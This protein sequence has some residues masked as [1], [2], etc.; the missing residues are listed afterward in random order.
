MTQHVL[1]VDDDRAECEILQRV[2]RGAEIEALIMTD[3]RQAVALVQQNSFDAIFVD[4]GMPPPD[5]ME[6]TRL[7]RAS[8]TNAKTPVIMITGNEDPSIVA[9]GFKAGITFFLYKPIVKDRL[10]NL[11]RLSRSVNLVEKR[12]FQRV[13]VRR[14]VQVQFERNALEGVTLDVSLNGMLIRAVR[15]LPPGSRLKVSLDLSPD[16]SPLIVNGLV[17]RVTDQNCMGIHFDGIA[18]SE[19]K[20]LQHF[21]LPLMIAPEI[22]SAPQDATAR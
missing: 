4:V 14:K 3:S 13:G 19:S 16:E 7:I 8:E 12:R 9:R 11:V 2:L 10:L 15:T 6:V 1:V 18:I 5:G 21:L 17:A 22:P 20:Q